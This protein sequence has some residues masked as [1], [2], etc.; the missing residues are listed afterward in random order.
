MLNGRDAIYPV[1]VKQSSIF[2]DRPHME[3]CA[4]Q[5]QKGR[6]DVFLYKRTQSASLRSFVCFVRILKV[7]VNCRLE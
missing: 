7:Y 6:L 3:A 4:D 2:A 5:E 1:L